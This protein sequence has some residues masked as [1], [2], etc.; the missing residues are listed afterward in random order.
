MDLEDFDQQQKN[1]PDM[2]DAHTHDNQ[3]QQSE[4]DKPAETSM[5]HQTRSV[6]KQQK[7]K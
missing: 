5:K 4:D 3:L 6:T 1:E 2:A 7:R